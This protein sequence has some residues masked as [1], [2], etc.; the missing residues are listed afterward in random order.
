MGKY[1]YLPHEGEPV[2]SKADFEETEIGNHQNNLYDQNED[3]SGELL[4]LA[5]GKPID[6]SGDEA[7][8]LHLDTVVHGASDALPDLEEE[9]DEAARWLREHSHE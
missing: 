7:A 4:D 8:D 5:T 3:A 6:N 2:N 9:D 1:E